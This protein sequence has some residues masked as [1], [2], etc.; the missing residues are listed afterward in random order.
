MRFQQFIE[1][2]VNKKV[3]NKINEVKNLSKHI[4]G[5]WEV[6]LQVELFFKLQ[7]SDQTRGLKDFNREPHY[8]SG[9][10]ADFN[11]VPK[12]ADQSTTWVELKVQRN[13]QVQQPIAEFKT[14]FDKIK[15]VT[16][17]PNDTAGAMV[18]VARKAKDALVE[19]ARIFVLDKD[20][21]LY[22]IVKPDSISSKR[23]LSSGDFGDADGHVVVMYVVKP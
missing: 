7:D 3:Q 22:F 13:E 17:G 20:K 9:Q 2:I 5:G 1:D 19:A 15:A 16:I 14:D 12:N 21:V 10:R 8:S 23:S 4:D 18:V 11:F 6:W